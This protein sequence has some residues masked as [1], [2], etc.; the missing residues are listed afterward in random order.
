MV[1]LL[2]VIVVTVITV[3]IYSHRLHSGAP[4]PSTVL[5]V[6]D[7]VIVEIYII[8]NRGLEHAVG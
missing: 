4:P 7:H 1:F 6:T 2:I 3:I 8:Y 5:T